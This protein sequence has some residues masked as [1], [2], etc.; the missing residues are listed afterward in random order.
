M[1]G[2]EN[3]VRWNSTADRAWQE[4]PHPIMPYLSKYT[5]KRQGYQTLKRLLKVE[6]N[7]PTDSPCSLH[8]PSQMI[9]KA[10]VPATGR[11]IS[12]VAH[13]SIAFQRDHCFQLRCI[14]NSL[15]DISE[16]TILGMSRWKRQHTLHTAF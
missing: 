2:P 10:R 5:F 16:A 11:T 1:P 7:T 4:H 6:A 12:L 3:I 8:Y 9:I 15:L 14:R 13:Y